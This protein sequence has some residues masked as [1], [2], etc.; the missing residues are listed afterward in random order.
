VSAVADWNPEGKPKLLP[1]TRMRYDKVR[2]S[3]VLL[4]PE[5]AV[6]LNSTAAEILELCDGT[7]TVPDVVGALERKYPGA[8]V[9][10]DVVEL[11]HEAEKK[12]WIEWILPA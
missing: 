3:H 11:I 7:R 8:E 5:R 9:R 4:L 10:A 12:G 6:I 2:Q 1:K